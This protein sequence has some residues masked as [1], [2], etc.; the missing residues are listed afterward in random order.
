[1]IYKVFRA[2]TLSVAITGTAPMWAAL[3]L[4]GTNAAWADVVVTTSE[5]NDTDDASLND[6]SEEEDTRSNTK[7][8]CEEVSDANLRLS[9]C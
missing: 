9:R 3:G 7:E 1:M 5:G 8:T 6:P 4:G 2:V